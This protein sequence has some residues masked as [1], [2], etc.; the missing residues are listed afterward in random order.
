MST[1]QER[2]E[3]ETYFHDKIPLT[4]SMGVRVEAWDEER[5]VLTAPL[6]PNHNHLGTAFG[7]SLS[8][9]A[10][11]AGYGLI[12]LALGGRDGHVV[13]RDSAMRYRRPVRG[14]IRAVCRMPVTDVLE[15]FK[16]EFA[17]KG[18][19]HLKLAVT[20]E[21]GESLDAATFEGTFVAMR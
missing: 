2:R 18:K 16:E 8:A 13:I 7:G 10:T 14:E 12:W 5:L 21:N 1:E 6:E 11:L 17:K 3:I 20:I 4:K 15:P 9:I 19:A